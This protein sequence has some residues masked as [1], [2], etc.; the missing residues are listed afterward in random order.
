MISTALLQPSQVSV[1]VF[2]KDTAVLSSSNKA[3]S[4]IDLYRN[5]TAIADPKEPIGNPYATGSIRDISTVLGFS[6]F[7]GHFAITLTLTQFSVRLP[8]L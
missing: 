2:G 1:N 4:H 7:L 8:A 3:C 6:V 5:V